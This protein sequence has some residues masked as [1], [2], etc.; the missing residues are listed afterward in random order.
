VFLRIDSKTPMQTHHV[1]GLDLG[2]PSEYTALA[3]LQ[4][5]APL[6]PP[7]LRD[8]WGNEYP[9]KPIGPFHPEYNV[10]ALRRWPLGTAYTEIIAGLEQFLQTQPLRQVPVVLVVDATGAGYPVCRMVKEQ[11]DQARVRGWQVAVTITEGS[12]V[13]LDE[14]APDVGCWRVAKKQLVS[15]LQVLLGTRRLRVAAGLKEAPTLLREL[16]TFRV[17]S[18]EGA[19]NPSSPGGNAPM[20]TWFSPWPWPAGPRKPWTASWCA[21]EAVRGPTSLTAWSCSLVYY[22]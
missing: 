12:A 11:L 16:Q 7:P 8:I 19:T 22:R 3:L 20:T 2:R 15:Q 18:T 10:R 21:D 14:S 6:P 9:R 1:I 4:W 5:E 13:T 17:K